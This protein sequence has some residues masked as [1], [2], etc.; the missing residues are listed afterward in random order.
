MGMLDLMISCC[1]VIVA[2]A[3]LH[4]R[5]GLVKVV[6]LRMLLLR[7]MLLVIVVGVTLIALPALVGLTLLV[8][9]LCFRLMV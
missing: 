7:V 3:R 2:I 8:I 1:S 5:R 6:L 4:A 9:V